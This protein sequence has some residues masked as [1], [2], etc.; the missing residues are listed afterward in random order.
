MISRAAL[1][2]GHTLQSVDMCC[3]ALIPAEKRPNRVWTS[4]ER[5]FESLQL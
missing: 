5:Q 3:L 4:N 1:T 2:S